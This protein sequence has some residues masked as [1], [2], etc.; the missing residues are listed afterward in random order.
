MF[1]AEKPQFAYYKEDHDPHLLVQV[2]WLE[3]MGV[4]FD[5]TPKSTPIYRMVPEF[6]RWLRTGT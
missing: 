2:D 4:V 5:V 3:E 1:W 6:I